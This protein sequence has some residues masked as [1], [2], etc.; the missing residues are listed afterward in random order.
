MQKNRQIKIMKTIKN[1]KIFFFIQIILSLFIC[2]TCKHNL[3]AQSTRIEHFDSN[4][5]LYR[6]SHY[7]AGNYLYDTFYDCKGNEQA[8]FY[9]NVDSL[10]IL[11]DAK[12][13][14]ENLNIDISAIIKLHGRYFY[15]YGIV[16]DNQGKVM[17]IQKLT[18][19]DYNIYNI[20]NLEKKIELHFY[21]SN[22][23]PAIKNKEKIYFFYTFPLVIVI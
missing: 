4:N 5:C 20:G 11:L 19:R 7:E 22:W 14:Y 8:V 18:K 17:H 15:L 12:G 1:K 23:K 9:K 10:P 21:K 13:W 3:L 2:T 6:V 16:I